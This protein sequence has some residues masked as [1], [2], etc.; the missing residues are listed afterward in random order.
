MK[1]LGLE[2]D[3]LDYNR[4]NPQIYTAFVRFAA[5]AVASGRPRFSAKAIIERMRWF[6]MIEAKEDDFKIN[7]NYT[8]FY[9]KKFMREYPQHD[10]FFETRGREVEEIDPLSEAVQ[11]NLLG[12]SDGEAAS[13]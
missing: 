4:D 6:T 7:N 5:Q 10:G 9:A 8:T 13:R 12:D 1:N 2:Q 11:L 3:F